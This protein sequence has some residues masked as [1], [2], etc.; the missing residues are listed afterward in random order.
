MLKVKI[1]NITL[2]IH[3]VI[4]NNI[5]KFEKLW[6]NSSW[7]NAQTLF[8]SPPPALHLQINNWF[9]L[10]IPVNKRPNNYFLYKYFHVICVN[11]LI[12]NEHNVTYKF[13]CGSTASLALTI[14]NGNRME[15][16]HPLKYKIRR[17][18]NCWF[19]NT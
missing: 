13:C 1:I 5:S 15:K 11:I 18:I 19:L 2:D 7:V 6:L 14:N 8:G 4:S 12:N 3:F 9:F 10:W 17:L 16:R